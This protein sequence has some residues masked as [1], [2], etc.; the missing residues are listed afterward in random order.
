MINTKKIQQEYCKDCKWFMF[1]YEFQ[2]RKPDSFD[3]HT[4]KMCWRKQG[5]CPALIRLFISK[6]N[7]KT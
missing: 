4:E 6:E 3:L 5:E 7:E 2:N 1:T